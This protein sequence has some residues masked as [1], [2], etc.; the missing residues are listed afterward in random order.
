M[1]ENFSIPKVPTEVSNRSS[2]F[3]S[4]WTI[5]VHQ[6]TWPDLG[7][8]PQSLCIHTYMK[9]AWGEGAAL[10]ERWLCNFHRKREAERRS[11]ERGGGFKKLGV[12]RGWPNIGDVR[13]SLRWGQWRVHCPWLAG[14]QAAPLSAGSPSCLR[15]VS[16]RTVKPPPQLLLPSFPTW[17]PEPWLTAP[18]HHALPK[19]CH[20]HL[21]WNLQASL[22]TKSPSGFRKWPCNATPRSFLSGLLTAHII[23]FL[24][25]QQV[26][27]Q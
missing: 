9:E 3:A 12:E 18:H 8:V 17:H 24:L 16:L 2:R 6:V 26:I 1:K 14:K 11:S 5:L 27:F 15:R 25:S 7:Q 21:S 13:Q 22:A 23:Q 4:D 10:N 20:S 19:T